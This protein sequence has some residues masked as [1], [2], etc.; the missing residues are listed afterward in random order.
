MAEL[1]PHHS[2]V[3][4]IAGVDGDIREADDAFLRIVGYS[5]EDFERDGLNWR[6]L[7]APEHAARDD[8]YLR[9]AAEKLLAGGFTA[10][11]VKAFIR[12]D[13]THVRVLVLGAFD[14]N[15]EPRW[16]GYIVDLSSAVGQT[17][18]RDAG[19]THGE[20]RADEFFTRL[21]GELVR[22]RTRMLAMLDNT[23][24]LIWAVDPHTRLLEANAP[25][26]AA[27]Q[28]ALGRDVALGEP[29]LGL[30]YPPE[31]LVH[32]E[33]AYA[34]ALAGERLSARTVREVAGRRV[35]H[36]TV[37]SPIVDPR[38]GVVGA[39]AISHDVTARVEAEDALRESEQRFRSIASASPIGIFLADATGSVLYVNPR[40]ALIWSMT[41]RETLDQG[42]KQRI[43]PDDREHILSEARAAFQRGHELDFEY[44]LLWPDGQLRHVHVWMAP[45]RDGLRVTGFVGG[46]QDETERH[47]L[48]LR[49]RQRERMESLGALAGGIAHD[50]NNMLSVVFAHVETAM[51]EAGPDASFRQNLEAIHTAGQ[52]ARDL[53]RQILTFCRTAERPAAERVD[54]GAVVL[55]GLSLL[56]ST[57]PATIGLD[58]RTPTA[59]VVVLG[60]A[61]ELQQILVNLCTNAAHAMSSRG[62]ISVRLEAIGAAPVGEAILSVSDTGCGMTTETQSRIFEPFFTTRR[63]GEGTGL[64]LAVVHGLVTAH[65]GTITVTSAPQAGATFRVSLPLVSGVPERTASPPPPPAAIQSCRILLVEDEPGVAYGAMMMLKRMGYEVTHASDAIEALRIF[66]TAP[67]A[68]DVVLSDLAMP[69]LSGDRLAQAINIVRPSLPII[70]M[71]GYSEPLRRVDLRQLGVVATLA[72]PWSSA[73]LLASIQLALE[74]SS[75]A[76]GA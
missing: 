11:Y 19:A 16:I 15:A 39:S 32:W 44:R 14:P 62:T 72:K 37:L 8:A 21:I 41:E 52:H 6:T 23:T 54:L 30:G 48:A 76:S 75:K 68:V 55:E 46:V 42:W 18:P 57:L 5:R 59:P 56:R 61:T 70:L 29:L 7:T 12:K 64:G 10:P 9:E 40:A 71:T 17:W 65:G 24:A 43:H 31:T 66:S 38:H 4:V 3:G 67:D 45:I 51:E 60:D 35:H 53:V 49:T 28:R 13:G 36:E 74:T 34:K 33:A 63:V 50:F 73:E 69:G 20:P 25:F 22:E 2:P 27:L 1:Q 26:R 47:A 58:I